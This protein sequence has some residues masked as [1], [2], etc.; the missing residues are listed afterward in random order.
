MLTENPEGDVAC[1]DVDWIQVAQDTAHQLA[2]CLY[3]GNG[4]LCLVSL[5]PE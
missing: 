1:L 3:N 2:G 4:L 5:S